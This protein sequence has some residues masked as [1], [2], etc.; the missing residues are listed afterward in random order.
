MTLE[1]LQ[2]QLAENIQRVSSFLEELPSAYLHQSPD[3]RWTIGEEL[4]HLT[5]SNMGTARLLSQPPEQLR[6]AE[7]PSRSY[8]EVV[9]EYK[10]KY[11]QAETPRGPQSTQPNGDALV[12]KFTLEA[13]WNK[14]SQ[15]LLKS[16]RAWSESE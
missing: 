7:Q 11:A 1:V 16:I 14:A 9:R 5:K 3:N 8:K 13:E 10:E 6:E 4:F 15:A 12:D 2:D